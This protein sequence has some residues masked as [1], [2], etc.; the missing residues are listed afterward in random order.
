MFTVSMQHLMQKEGFHRHTNMGRLKGQN[1]WKCYMRCGRIRGIRVPAMAPALLITRQQRF[2]IRP[3]LNNNTLG[4]CYG[5]AKQKSN[6][7]FYIFHFF[8]SLFSL[9]DCATFIRTSS[10]RITTN[11]SVESANIS[12]FTLFF[13]REK[14]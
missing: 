5:K 2:T 14:I 12:G 7:A 8:A 6:N 9:L 1:I 11:I 13:V 10:A 4:A 3:M